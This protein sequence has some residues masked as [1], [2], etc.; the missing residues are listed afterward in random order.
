M[1]TP[2]SGSTQSQSLTDLVYGFRKPVKVVRWSSMGLDFT[3]A[4]SY[5]KAEFYNESKTANQ[6]N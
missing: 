1:E 5:G 2:S 3:Q 4:Y 6:E